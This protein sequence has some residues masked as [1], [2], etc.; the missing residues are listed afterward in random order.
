MAM[1]AQEGKIY[2]AEEVG[3][4]FLNMMEEVQTRLNRLVTLKMGEVIEIKGGKFLLISINTSVAQI[5]LQ[6]LKKEEAT[7]G[8]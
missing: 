5:T 4:D 8:S 6:L 3:T 1:D 2:S 7:S